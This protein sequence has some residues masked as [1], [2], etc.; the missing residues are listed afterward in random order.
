MIP[1]AA[2]KGYVASVCASCR[3]GLCL[4][5]WG[6]QPTSNSYKRR[7]NFGFIQTTKPILSGWHTLSAVLLTD[8]IKGKMGRKNM[9]ST[10][11]ERLCNALLALSPGVQAADTWERPCPGVSD[12]VVSDQWSSDPEYFFWL[13]QRMHL[14]TSLLP[15]QWKTVSGCP[16]EKWQKLRKYLV[17]CPV[18]MAQTMQ[19]G[20]S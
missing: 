16:Q 12:S 19:I 11:W 15:V 8:W 1:S 5:Y 14:Q 13:T 10:T 3:N 18:L 20:Q 17:P 2:H 6:M 7:K 9:W 4:F